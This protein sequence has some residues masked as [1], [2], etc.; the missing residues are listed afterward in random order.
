MPVDKISRDRHRAG[1]LTHLQQHV[2]RVAMVNGGQAPHFQP[3][4]VIRSLIIRGLLN[5]NRRITPEGRAAIAAIKYPL[6]KQR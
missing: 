1:R 2:L 4:G 6:W 3:Y 5:H